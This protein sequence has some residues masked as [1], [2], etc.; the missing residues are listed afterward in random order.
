[1]FFINKFDLLN[2]FVDFDKSSDK[3]DKLDLLT[4]NIDTDIFINKFDLLNLFGM[5]SDKSDKWDLLT[6][7]IGADVL[8]NKFDL[9]YLYWMVICCRF[10]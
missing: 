4:S 2:L 8:I 7:N 10:R 1:M 9:F 3:P 5:L 6:S